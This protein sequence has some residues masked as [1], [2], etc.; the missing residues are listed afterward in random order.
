MDTKRHGRR[1]Y[2]GLESRRK[3]A[4]RLFRQGKRQ[5][6]IVRLLEV[7]RQSASRWYQMWKAGGMKGLGRTGKPGRNCRLDN[8]DLKAIEKALLK[9]A[10]ANGFNTDLWTLRRI[11]QVIARVTGVK[12][13]Q[14]HVW[15][16]LARKMG[17]SLQ[18]PAKRAKEK[19]EE[20]VSKWIKETWPE[21]KKSPPEARMVSFPRRK[22]CLAKA[23]IET[24][25]GSQRRD[26]GG[27]PF[28]Q[29]E[30]AVYLCSDCL[31]LG[32]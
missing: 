30:E 1:D 14:G 26:S 8:K 13:H 25:V 27:R 22:W 2:E 32:R 24:Y 16:I 9:G 18:R 28:F 17:W 23:S 4:G 11:G 6:D 5:A 3:Q 10:R 20:A 19:N 31:S 15:R 29:L 12:Y 7:S 21:L